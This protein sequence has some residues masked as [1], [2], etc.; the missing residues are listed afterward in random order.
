MTLLIDIRDK[1]GS[2]IVELYQKTNPMKTPSFPEF[3][4]RIIVPLKIL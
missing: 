3:W 1:Y 4:K 2:L